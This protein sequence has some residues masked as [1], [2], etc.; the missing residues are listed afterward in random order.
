MKKAVVGII[1]ISILLIVGLYYGFKISY[2]SPKESVPEPI[3]KRI[4]EIVIRQ[5]KVPEQVQTI[6]LKQNEEIVLKFT[7]DKATQVHLHGYDRL[8]DISPGETQQ[9]DL[10]ATLTGRF[11]YELE[12]SGK[13]LGVLEV[14]P[15]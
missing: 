10:K 5:E 12:E 14:T 3:Q 4:I 9:I 6:A 7:A 1:A 15:P 8:V 11:E 13:V 2:N